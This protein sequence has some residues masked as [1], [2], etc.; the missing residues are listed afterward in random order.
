M[1]LIL[2]HRFLELL[3]PTSKSWASAGNKEEKAENG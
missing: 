1:R 3:M 2:E